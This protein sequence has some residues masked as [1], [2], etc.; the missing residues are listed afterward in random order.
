MLK[1]EAKK[2]F[3]KM[4]ARRASCPHNVMSP[5]ESAAYDDKESSE[6]DRDRWA[7]LRPS[8]QMH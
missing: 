3:R 5:K 1:E 7:Q 6:E 4:A 2:Q 8:R